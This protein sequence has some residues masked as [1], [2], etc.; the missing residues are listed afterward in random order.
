MLKRS[1]LPRIAKPVVQNSSQ[2]GKSKNIAES[3][4]LQK[5]LG[6]FGGQTKSELRKI[7]LFLEERCWK[8]SME[9]ARAWWKVAPTLGL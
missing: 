3:P 2:T 4:A 6:V 8:K 1:D 9:S 5:P 7:A